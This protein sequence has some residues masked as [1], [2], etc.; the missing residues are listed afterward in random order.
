MA[1]PLARIHAHPLRDH[2]LFEYQGD[3]ASP[4]EVAR[5]L[6]QPVN[7]VSYH[8]AVLVRHGCLELVRTERRR[9][10]TAHYYRSTVAQAIDDDD[11]VR[12]PA[13]LRRAL[14]LG[15]LRVV[16]DEAH[17]AALAGA[18][19]ARRAHLTRSHLTLDDEGIEA[20]S[21]VLLA[22]FDELAQIARESRMRRSDAHSVYE[23]AILAFDNRAAAAR[24]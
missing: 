14:T 21:R 17:A 5:R 11:W 1:D 15:T 9:G 12:V 20:A 7:L 6:G 10:A 23:V 3:P 2:V 13:P 4:S 8:T 24:A 19:D 18:F 16:A 22:A